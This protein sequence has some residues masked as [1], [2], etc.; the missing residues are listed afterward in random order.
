MNIRNLAIRSLRRLKYASFCARVE[1]IVDWVF[2]V[3][4]QHGR[5]MAVKFL[6]H[7]LSR[8]K[9]Q[10]CLPIDLF[11]DRTIRNFRPAQTHSN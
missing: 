9:V 4:R 3:T 11:R 10:V 5:G 8:D 1:P 7:Y 2:L 6:A